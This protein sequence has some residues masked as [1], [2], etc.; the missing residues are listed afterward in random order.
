[1]A[2]TTR[3]APMYGG[4]KIIYGLLFLVLGVW[5]GYDMWVS[6]P[7]RQATFDQWKA[8]KDEYAGLREKKDK[9][10]QGVDVSPEDLARYAQLEQQLK[11]LSPD[12]SELVAP[13][14]LDRVV[15]W[16]YLSCLP[17]AP[18]FL[19]QYVKAKRQ[20]YRLDDDGTLYFEG[21]PQLGSGAWP[22]AEI[23]DIDMSRWM[24]KSIA[25]PMHKDG[26]RLVLD[27]YLHKNLHLIIG[28]IASRF[29]PTQW[30]TE[31]KLIKNEAASPPDAAEATPK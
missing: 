19:W 31:A 4:Q 9:L 14:A 27:A 23:A 18:V 6:I 28:V 21:D 25:Y 16:V 2:I 15:Q 24:M 7:R 26:R 13:G 12:G 1:M 22:Q 17:F 11:A 30:D 29:Y 3:I 8:L 20:K 5:G 10:P